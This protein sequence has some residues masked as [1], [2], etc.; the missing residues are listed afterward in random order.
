MVIG[1]VQIAPGAAYNWVCVTAPGAQTPIVMQ[2]ACLFQYPG[3]VTIA[4][5]Q[6]VND[7]F[8]WVCIAPASGSFTDP[9]T[10]TTVTT[11]IT[12]NGAVTLITSLTGAAVTFDYNG[13][14]GTVVQDPNGGYIAETGAGSTL[15]V[16]TFTGG[17]ST[18][19]ILAG[20]G[21]GSTLPI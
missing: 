9:T 6:D 18:L 13:T 17:G 16:L 11:L 19:P 2:A 21:A 5:P 14:S 10:G 4:Y 12:A 8:S 1:N 7:A 15:P 3:Q 20:D